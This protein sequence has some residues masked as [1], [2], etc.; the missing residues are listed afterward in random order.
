MELFAVSSVTNAIPRYFWN[1]ISEFDCELRATLVGVAAQRP[2]HGQLAL[3]HYAKDSLGLLKK[4][5]Q[6]L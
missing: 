1:P 2:G 3:W 6:Y 5:R 4:T